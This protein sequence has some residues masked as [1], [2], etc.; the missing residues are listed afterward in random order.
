MIIDEFNLNILRSITLK[1]NTE[2]YI[3][4]KKLIDQKTREMAAVDD[5]DSLK[6]L[7]LP[8]FFPHDKY[9]ELHHAAD[10][11][12]GIQHKII[13]H[14]IH[15]LNPD[16]LIDY[17]NLPDWLS[18]FLNWTQ[19]KKYPPPIGR[20]DIV[21]SET[22]QPKICEIN[23]DSSVGGGDVFSFIEL[24]QLNFPELLPSG[25]KTDSFYHDLSIFMTETLKMNR[26][27][28]IMILD[29]STWVN[30][31]FINYNEIINHFQKSGY[32]V[33]VITEKH[34]NQKSF[35]TD[36]KL[37]FRTFLKEDM[38]NDLETMQAFFNKN[39]MIISG[40][41]S[42][43]YSSKKWL[44]MFY[45]STFQDYLTEEEKTTIQQFI[46]FT[47]QVDAENCNSILKDHNR[48][49]YKPEDAY[50]GTG[51][52]VGKYNNRKKIET[53]ILENSDSKWIAQEYL[54]ESKLHVVDDII[55]GRPRLT[56]HHVV[57][58]LYKAGNTYSGL[59]VRASRNN[60]IV[61][62]STGGAAV[63]WGLPV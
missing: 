34:I 7:Y 32:P 1:P 57:L 43:I 4:L 36:D 50:G 54:P 29:W 23:L 35:I 13:N 62:V 38:Q 12:I 20:F 19:I 5:G 39:P 42:D 61:N 47:I 26:L 44:S 22:G 41:E 53:T 25:Y 40:F 27:Q 14:L 15:D 59:G 3:R 24:I 55:D 45:E 6:S 31:G 21:I 11:L 8:I 17:F 51:I 10:V 33:S 58:G 37:F 60:E 16:Q 48:F 56:S 46:P 30:A 63:G 9:I 49:I 28:E 18:P 2:K 52:L